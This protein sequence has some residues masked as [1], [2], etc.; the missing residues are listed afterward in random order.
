MTVQDFRVVTFATPLYHATLDEMLASAASVGL[1][2]EALRLPNE[3]KSWT[4]A[5]NHKPLHI[6]EVIHI[7]NVPVVWVDADARFNSFPHLFNSLECDFACRYLQRS[8]RQ[9]LLSGTLFFSPTPTSL[10]LLEHWNYVCSRHPRTWDQ[11]NLQSAIGSFPNLSTILLPPSYC[12]IV[13]N[14][15]NPPY[16]PVISHTQHSR[17]TAHL[18][19]GRGS[20]SI[21]PTETPLA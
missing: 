21:P 18:L 5:T 9:E 15:P 12:H 14:P 4:E 7:S 10:R 16:T 20:R 19:G 1:T 2:V 6:L 11:S 17:K 8:T 3:F 13:N